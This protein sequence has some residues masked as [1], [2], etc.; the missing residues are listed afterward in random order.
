M[1]YFS[2]GTEGEMYEEEFCS[3][4]VHYGEAGESCAILQVH[5]IWNYD[6]NRKDKKE[7]RDL[8]DDL[9]PRLNDGNEECNM[10][11]A[12]REPPGLKH[13][14]ACRHYGQEQDPDAS[15]ADSGGLCARFYGQP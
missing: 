13:L 3:R 1:G 12:K 8:L 6:Q 14:L 7:I 11:H 15:C 5:A 2:N 10:F 4:C 9:I